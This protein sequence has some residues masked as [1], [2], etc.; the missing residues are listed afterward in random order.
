MLVDS[1]L[2]K[3]LECSNVQSES[4]TQVASNVHKYVVTSKPHSKC[5]VISKF[6]AKLSWHFQSV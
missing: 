4:T 5:L 3:S 1:W 2:L 6:K